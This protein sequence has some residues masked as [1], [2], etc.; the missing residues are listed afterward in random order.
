MFCKIATEGY[1][2]STKIDVC[3]IK[4]GFRIT[5][6]ATFGY[7][8]IGKFFGLKLYLVVD[9]NGNIISA[10]ITPGNVDDRHYVESL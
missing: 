8:S 5:E 7:S 2:Y 1:I 6:N 4:R 3:H 10:S 9:L